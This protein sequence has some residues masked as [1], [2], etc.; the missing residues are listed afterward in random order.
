MLHVRSVLSSFC[1]SEE[2]IS[3][4]GLC[5]YKYNFYQKEDQV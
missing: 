2:T 4:A 3:E 5:R 1:V